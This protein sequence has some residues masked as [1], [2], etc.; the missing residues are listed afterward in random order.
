MQKK[1]KNEQIGLAEKTNM[2]SLREIKDIDKSLARIYLGRQMR[3]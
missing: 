2:N 3:N 1:I